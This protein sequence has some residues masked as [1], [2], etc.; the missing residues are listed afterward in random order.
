MDHKRGQLMSTMCFS[1]PTSP[2]PPPLPSCSCIPDTPLSYGLPLGPCSPLYPVSHT[3]SRLFC[4]LAKPGIL[5]KGIKMFIRQPRPPPPPPSTKDEGKF[6]KTHHVRPKK[7]FGMPS[8]HSSALAFYVFYLVPALIL[9]DSRSS[10]PLGLGLLSPIISLVPPAVLGLV[11]QVFHDILG[12][13]SSAAQRYPMA[14]EAM[15][16]MAKGMSETYDHWPAHERMFEVIPPTPGTRYASALAI[17][18]YFLAGIW[19]RVELGYHT[20]PQ[21]LGGVAWGGAL[22]LIWRALWTSHPNWETTLQ[23]CI[24]MIWAMATEF[25]NA[26]MAEVQ[27]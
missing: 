26:K 4:S 22:A 6:D 24:E 25:I 23:Q 18:G 20:W 11:S 14:E 10:F 19:S 17:T 13:I 21:V 5:A 1:R 9:P 7:T 27:A 12:S 15:R 8:T 16:Q 3:V 2:S